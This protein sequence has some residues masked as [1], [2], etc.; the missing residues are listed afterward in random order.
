[1]ETVKRRQHGSTYKG[2]TIPYGTLVGTSDELKKV[3]YTYGYLRDEDL[4]EM[5]CPPIEGEY[6]DPE[7]EA[8]KKEMVRVVDEVLDTLTPRSKKVLCL[9]YGIGLTQDY[10]LEEVGWR[11]DV[12]RERIRQIEAKALRNLKHPSRG[13]TLRQLIGY[14]LTTAEKKAEEESARTRWEKERARA[15]E[16]REARAQAKIAR[17]N[18][19]FKQRREVEERMYKA[20]RELRKKWDELKPMVSDVEWVKHLEKSDPDMYQELKYLVGD[21]WGTNAK[22][23]W[24]MYA[25]KEK[26]YERRRLSS[27]T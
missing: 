16:Q 3:Y 19:I 26:R 17:D 21:I 7:E 1:M 22:I 2:H 18:A 12:T 15:E 6:V 10:T 14:Y 4:P 8:H 13:D 5:P 9:R 23:V 11:F 24:E 25:E 20:D 27:G